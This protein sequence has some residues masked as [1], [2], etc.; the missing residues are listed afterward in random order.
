MISVARLTCPTEN[1]GD[2]P[3]SARRLVGRIRSLAIATA[4]G[5]QSNSLV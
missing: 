4:T 2:W 1:V 5:V 3:L